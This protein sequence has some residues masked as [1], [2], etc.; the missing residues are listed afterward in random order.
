LLKVNIDNLLKSRSK[1]REKYSSE[2]M[3]KPRNVVIENRDGELLSKLISIIEEN[4]HETEFGVKTLADGAGLSRMQLYRK[5]KALVNKT[6]HEMINAFRMERAAQILVQKQMTVSEVAY[7]VGFNT[8]KY[9]SRCFKEQFGV[10]PTE[11]V[12][13]Q[14]KKAKEE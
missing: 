8:P 1:L 14:S 11:Y 3:I 12:K 7:E 5:L 9:F 4:M 13:E 2:L 6:P 10:L